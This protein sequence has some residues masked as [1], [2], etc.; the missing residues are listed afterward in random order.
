M[1]GSNLGFKGDRKVSLKYAK[2]WGSKLSP[3]MD[4]LLYGIQGMTWIPISE[5]FF[6]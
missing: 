4:G 3:S 5:V 1:Y 2:A 6:F